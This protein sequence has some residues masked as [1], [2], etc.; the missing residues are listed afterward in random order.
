MFGEKVTVIS[1]RRLGDQHIPLP[2][3]ADVAAQLG[4]NRLPQHLD[5]LRNGSKH[6]KFTT[7]QSSC[8]RKK[9]K[10]SNFF[11]AWSQP[12]APIKLILGTSAA[13]LATIQDPGTLAWVYI[14][15]PRTG[16]AAGNLSPP[17]SRWN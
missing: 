12:A 7:L 2:L 16:S 10:S 4:V 17:F 15:R 14:T 9:L 3:T 13:I 5:R 8:F 11:R 6:K 1:R